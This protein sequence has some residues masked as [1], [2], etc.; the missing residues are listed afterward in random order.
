[1]LGRP[2]SSPKQIHR[3]DGSR[4]VASVATLAAVT[5]L[6]AVA[7]ALGRSGGGLWLQFRFTRR[8]ARKIARGPNC[9]D[10]EARRVANKRKRTETRRLDNYSEIE[11][12]VE[13]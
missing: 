9:S 2:S 7:A 12:H 13:I 3:I 11:I 8:D 4:G 6:A 5:P 10:T 1:M